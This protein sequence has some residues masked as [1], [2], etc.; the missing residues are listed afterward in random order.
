MA[1]EYK[2]VKAEAG[3]ERG[4]II[5]R[6]PYNPNYIA[7]IKTIEGYKWHPEEKYWSIPYSEL[8]KLLS[9]FG[10]EKINVALSAWLYELKKELIARKY[11]RRI[12]SSIS[13]IKHRLILILIYSAGLRVGEVVRLKVE[14]IDAKRRLIRIKGGKGGKDRYT[15]LSEVALDALKEYKEKYKPEKWLFPGQRKD[16][17][18]TIRTAQKIFENAC[19][20][21]GIKKE[22]TIHSLRHSFATHLLESGVDLRYIQE[23]LGHRS[24]KTTEIYT[25]VTVKDLNIK[26]PLD[27]IMRGEDK[28]KVRIYHQNGK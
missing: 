17:H 16:K 25:H 3:I 10:G 26:S 27:L 4:R 22:V 28:E 7:K 9:I 13:N 12:L 18:I 20:K 6:F 19:K 24:S 5:V 8:E 21:T 23:L 11:S 15:I 2:G 14:D 1:T